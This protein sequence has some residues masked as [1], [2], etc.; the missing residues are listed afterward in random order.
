MKAGSIMS[1]LSSFNN[2]SRDKMQ[3]IPGLKSRSPT[4]VFFNQEISVKQS[5]HKFR[6]LLVAMFFIIS[7]S[8]CQPAQSS[9]T[10]TPDTTIQET[11][12]PSPTTAIDPEE[13]AEPTQPAGGFV[14]VDFPT[15]EPVV[16]EDAL[17][18]ESGLQY[19]EI[20]AGDGATPQDGSLVLMNF[21]ISLPEGSE[22]AN[23]YTDGSPSEIII[24]RGQLLPGWEE[25]VKLM[26]AGG[27]AELIL[28]PELALG[29]QGYGSVPPNSQ[30]IIEVEILSVEPAPEPYAVSEGDLTITESGL[31]Y[32][33]ISDGDGAEATE[34]DI[35]TNHFTI[36]IR[37]E[38]QDMYFGSSY[39]S[40]PISF[41][42]GRGDTVFP[43]WEEG[44]A[45]MRVGGKRL[46][47]IPPELALGEQGGSGIPANATLVMEVEL[48]EIRKPVQM[49]EVAE[50]DYTV[51][52]SGLKYYDIVEGEGASPITGQTVTV[53][54]TGW[55]EDGTIFDSSVERGQPFNFTIGTGMVIPG[56]DEGVATMKIGGRRQ[57]VVP[58][59]LAYGDVGAPPT[60]PPGATLIFE[61]ELLDIQE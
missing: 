30:L 32:F 23:T 22:L 17:V 43:G 26:K 48:V 28:P 29:E 44:M 15:P 25:G 54:Y 16:R 13:G 51:T 59:D 20:K 45:G 35:V 9:E 38:S 34:G 52:E 37:E 41:A 49:T 47:I 46:L 40:Q 24:G 50:E 5:N 57:L 36:W 19:I 11:E 27:K 2:Q 53:H 3:N 12:T 7:L 61:V 21:I 1:W 14:V 56:W 55:L 31:S 10:Q 18:T 39:N 4:R 42:L 8:A 6:L 58:S 33:D 60:I